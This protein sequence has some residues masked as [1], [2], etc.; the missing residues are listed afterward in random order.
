MQW[1]NPW[2]PPQTHTR[3][4]PLLKTPPRTLQLH[5]EAGTTVPDLHH[6]GVLTFVW[7]DRPVPWEVHGECV[8][9]AAS[10]HAAVRSPKQPTYSLP[11]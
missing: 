9:A 3:L 1:T 4:H 11:S 5:E 10:N 8:T 6:R 2:H 7:D